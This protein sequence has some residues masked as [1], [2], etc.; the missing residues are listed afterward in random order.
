MHAGQRMT[1]RG[2]T[3]DARGLVRFAALALLAGTLAAC[4]TSGPSERSPRV[5]RGPELPVNS[6]DPWGHHVR[7]ASAKYDVP[8]E[9][10]RAVIEVESGGN[11]HLDG[12]PI[13]SRAGAMGLMQIM[14][15]TW[16]N[17]RRKHGFGPDPHDPRENILAGTAYLREMYDRFGAPG[18][19]A[20][21]NAG[22]G[23]LEDHLAT[24]RP[25]PPETRNYVAMIHPATQDVSP[26]VRAVSYA[27]IDVPRASAD[28]VR[29]VQAAARAGRDDGPLVAAAPRPVVTVDRAPSPAPAPAPRIQSASLPAA[30]E[31]AP[32]RLPPVP[33]PPAAP[34][35]AVFQPSPA[36]PQAL[37]S[38]APRAA[39]PAPVPAAAPAAP[40]GM[41]PVPPPAA[42]VRQASVPAAGAWGVQVGAFRTVAQAERAVSDANRMAGATLRGARF[43]PTEVETNAGVLVRARLLGLDADAAVRACEEITAGGGACRVVRPD[44][45]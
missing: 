37:P 18:A 43:A 40:R 20:A 22:P 16:A 26:R 13:T 44:Q 25:L 11:T 32:I 39:A 1:Q 23:R 2:S 45:V 17:L 24:G 42:A 12:R 31:P 34:A 36:A 9:W 28:R 4:G 15:G 29:R 38:P 5:S 3:P 41:V 19:F 7:E 27:T 14:P 30:P 8:E 10:I 35:P 33:Q 21:Y 6:L